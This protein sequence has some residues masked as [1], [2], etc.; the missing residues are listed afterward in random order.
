MYLHSQNDVL[1]LHE[2]IDDQLNKI[3]KK[4]HFKAKKARKRMKHAMKMA[5]NDDDFTQNLFDLVNFFCDFHF[6]LIF[7]LYFL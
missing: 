5:R 7:F 6:E 1:E 3:F 2:S 4:K